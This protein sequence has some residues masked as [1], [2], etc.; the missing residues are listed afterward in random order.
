MIKLI[1]IKASQL[2]D[3]PIIEGQI[4]YC[5]DT[6][7]SYYDISNINRLTIGC[8]RQVNTYNKLVSIEKSIKELYIVVENNTIYRYFENNIIEVDDINM[9]LDILV[10]IESMKALPLI[11]NGKNI[12][13]IT[14]ASHTYTNDGDTVENKLK[15]I[16]SEDKKV[17]LYTRTEY[18]IAINNGQRVF[19]IPYP[20][21]NYDLAI[22][23]MVVIHGDRILGT[24]D[25]SISNDQLIINHNIDGLAKD[26]ILTFIFH[27]NV[28]LSND[29]LNAESINNVR[30]FVS[31]IEPV[32]KIETDVWFDTKKLEVKQF[33]KGKWKIIVKSSMADDYPF[34]IIKKTHTLVESSNYVE[35]GVPGFD[36]DKDTLL[37]Y[38]NSVY[39]EEGSDYTI[40]IDSNHI[41]NTEEDIWYGDVDDIVFNF[42]IL[43]STNKDSKNHII[44]S[45][46]ILETT[47]TKIYIDRFDK[48]NDTLFIYENSI[49]L[50]EGDDYVISSDSSHII[51]KQGNWDGTEEAI[52]FN[53]IILKNS[54]THN[55]EDLSNDNSILKSQIFKILD[56]SEDELNKIKD[57]IKYRGE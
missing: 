41:I 23:P 57:L 4:L 43:K 28:I 42:V 25:Y 37:V 40:S 50:E 27:Y 13:P 5:T 36:Q 16:M 19:T 8:T 2:V 54:K 17:L 39:L 48:N 38:M 47:S 46:Q 34:Y 26:E 33:I 35:I 49:Y 44:K 53:T 52:V 22:Y 12:A 56:M 11:Q 45:T 1:P 31:D 55:E 32:G 20:I 7:E 29:N 9:I 51:Q 21:P 30:F 14:L 18:V 3:Y 15:N 10:P 6:K 24:S